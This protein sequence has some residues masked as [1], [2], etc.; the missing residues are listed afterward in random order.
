[1]PAINKKSKAKGKPGY[2]RPKRSSS[3][4]AIIEPQFY[5][6]EVIENLDW[7]VSPV[8]I[9]NKEAFDDPAIR[10]I[11]NPGGT[12]STK[13]ISILQIIILYCLQNTGKIIDIVRKTKAELV[14]TVIL[15]LEHVL[16]GTEDPGDGKFMRG[17]PEIAH[18]VKRNLTKHTYKINGNIIRF[19]G[20]DKAG[21]KRGSKR[22]ILFCDEVN[23][24]TL[25][26]WIQLNIRTSFKVFTTWNP[27]EYFFL[28]TIMLEKPNGDKDGKNK[29]ALIKS[30]YLDA[31]DFLPES[32]I[33]EIERLIDIDDYWYKVYVLG[34]LAVIKGIIYAT[35]DLIEPSDYD[36]IDYADL[37]YGLD[38]GYEH[39]AALIEMKYYNERTYE[40][41]KFCKKHYTDDE[42]IAW[43]DAN[44]ISKDAPIYCDSAL[45]ASIRKLR[46]AGYNARKA[47]KDVL[48]GVRYV[49]DAKVV[50]CKSSVNFI[51]QRKR[52]KWV[53][54]ANGEIVE[55][56]AV[57]IDD[58]CCDA[59]RYGNYTHRNRLPD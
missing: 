19:L 56:T 16:T 57:K 51:R 27:S 52:Y 36:L 53:Q 8:F 20:M 38:F 46:D 12:R 50:V 22:D 3:L 32:M 34:E 49:Q 11:N 18:L 26:D 47:R 9:K 14:D 2:R 15:D 29:F 43:M 48:D 33:R 25:E 30:T 7:E 17:L 39:P 37:F 44:G 58:D 24:I 1:M 41:E 28:Y 35:T 6:T 54:K 4:P 40:R 23:F 42:L 59:E 55:G 31:Y 45:P 21:K 5:E 10:F 13:T